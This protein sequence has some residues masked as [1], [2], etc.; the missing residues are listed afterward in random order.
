MKRLVLDPLATTRLADENDHPD[1]SA[2]RRK[3]VEEQRKDP[4]LALII[5]KLET[6]DVV[7]MELE[8]ESTQPD[9]IQSADELQQASVPS[10][11]VAEKKKWKQSYMTLTAQQWNNMREKKKRIQLPFQK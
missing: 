7:R 5:A 9:S 3:I 8:D 2:V 4:K 1:F 11:S 6:A 10:A